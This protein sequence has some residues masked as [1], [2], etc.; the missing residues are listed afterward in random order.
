MS[1]YANGALRQETSL[2][3]QRLAT[4]AGTCVVSSM[5][6]VIGELSRE[7]GSIKIFLKQPHTQ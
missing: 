2:D 5:W 1:V 6:C 3:D 4:S 7:G